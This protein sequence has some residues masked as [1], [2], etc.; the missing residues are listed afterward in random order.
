MN[1]I[2]IVGFVFVALLGV[3]LARSESS[4]NYHVAREIPVPGDEGWDY[5]SF[6]A[7]SARL[8]LS[9]GSR[10]QVV[11]TNKNAVL[12]EVTDTPGV[13]GVAIANDLGRGYISAGRT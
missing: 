10:V 3:T 11:D 12:G 6:D 1:R 8:F 7:G 9:H 13:H 4:F 5:L 2:M